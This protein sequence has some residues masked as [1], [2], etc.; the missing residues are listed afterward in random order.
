MS[1]GARKVLFLKSNG[2]EQKFKAQTYVSFGNLNN[3][4]QLKW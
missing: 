1:I 4:I 2:T 3:G